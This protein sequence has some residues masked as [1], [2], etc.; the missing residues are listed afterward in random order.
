MESKISLSLKIISLIVKLR[1][2]QWI[3]YYFLAMLKEKKS[4]FIA[5]HFI[6]IFVNNHSLSHMT[7]IP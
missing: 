6:E 4:A 1:D 5:R 2:Q 3:D 7:I